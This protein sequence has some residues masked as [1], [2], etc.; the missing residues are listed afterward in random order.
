[1]YRCC[2]PNLG[3]TIKVRAC[4][5]A[6][7]EGSPRVTPHALGNVKQCEGMTLTLPRELSLWELESQWT[8]EFWEGDYRGQ[9]S[10]DWGIPYIIG[11]P[12]ERRCLKWAR[13]THLDIW[14]ISYG[15]K[16]GHESNCKF[17]SRPLKVRNGP[18]SLACWWYETYCWKALD[19]GYNFTLDLISIG[20][21]HTKLWNLKVARVP[22]LAILGF[23]LGSPRTKCHLDM[24]LV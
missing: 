17:D 7:Q 19:E 2:N 11:N 18:D 22:T 8:F 6:G 13:M 4:K 5:V 1:M 9:N 16:K 23:P 24:G 21:L 3:L 14:N 15:Q 20:G 12:L 10:M